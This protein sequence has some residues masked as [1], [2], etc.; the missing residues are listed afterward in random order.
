MGICTISY[1][2]HGLFL[3]KKSKGITDKDTALPHK[4]IILRDYG[5]Q[6]TVYF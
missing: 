6:E 5:D 1:V 3:K 2:I 4:S